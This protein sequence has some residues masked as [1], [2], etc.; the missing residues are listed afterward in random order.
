MNTLNENSRNEPGEPGSPQATLSVAIQGA[1]LAI[2]NTVVIVTIMVRAAEESQ[3]FLTWAIFSA[4]VIGG[5]IT[6]LQAAR[7]GRFGGGH[8]LLSGASPHFIAISVIALDIG[9]WATL[10]SLIVASSVAQFAFAAWLPLLR[11]IITP[12]V[13]GA[14]LMLIAI[15]VI[16]VAVDKLAKVP[17]G[18]ALFASPLVVAAT[19]GL[20]VVTNLKGSGTLRLWAPLIGILAGSL[21]AAFLGLYDLEFLKQ[22][23]WFAFPDFSAWPGLDLSLGTEFWTLLPTFVIVALVVAVKVGGD[24]VVIQQVSQRRS[25]AID[26]RVVQ[27]TVN[28]NGFGVLLSGI[29]GTLPPVVYSPSSITLIN[30]TG[31]A[32]RGVGYCAGVMLIFVAFFPK[33]TALLLAAPSAVMGSILLLVMGM[34]FVE[35]MRMVFREG[36]DQRNTLIVAVTLCVGFGVES[37]GVFGSR[38]GELWTLILANGTTVGILVMVGLTTLLEVTSPR[39]KRLEVDLQTSSLTV[40]DEFLQE[41]AKN[42]GWNEKSTERLRAA[43]EESLLCLMSS[44]SDEDD[45]NPRLII[46]IRLLDNIVEMDWLSVFEEQNIEDRLAYMSEEAEVNDDRELS[47][48][49]LRHHAKSVQHRKYHGVDIVTLEVERTG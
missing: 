18:T 32:Y 16:S 22:E 42:I 38:S 15:S 7:I 17:D 31:V 45:V 41:F 23:P 27:G 5:A 33:I 46:V 6:A 20:A 21:V 24:G 19:L 14:S 40:I 13:C 29:G 37:L 36:L 3:A 26:F 4:L 34:L 28:A 1:L 11:R 9:G 30:L 44:T 39:S 47:F 25:R 35:G 49:L 12:V 43:G 2:V 10:A 48:R 8:L